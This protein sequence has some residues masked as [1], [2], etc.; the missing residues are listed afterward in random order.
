MGKNKQTSKQTNKNKTRRPRTEEV[1]AV[2][3]VQHRAQLRA[4]G[5]LQLE[6]GAVPDPSQNHHGCQCSKT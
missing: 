6:R 5:V 1:L 2:L 3:A 4:G